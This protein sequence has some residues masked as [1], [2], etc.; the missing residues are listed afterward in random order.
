[1][2]TATRICVFLS[3]KTKHRAAEDELDRVNRDLLRRVDELQTLL[4][5]VPVGIA[6]ATDPDCHEI[7]MNPAG[8]AMLGLDLEANAS[9]SHANA[10]RLPFRVM[11]GGHE[12]PPDQLPM[13]VASSRNVQLRDIEVEVVHEDGRV[14]N[15]F[16]YA[17][18]LL[19]EQGN[20][21]GCLGVFIDISE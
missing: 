20:V 2:P 14:V 5:V 12:L 17:S 6:V 9:K 8:A 7:K 21:R 19:D 13:Q 18:P 16:E 11:R 1:I 10:D 4:D 15:L 3:D